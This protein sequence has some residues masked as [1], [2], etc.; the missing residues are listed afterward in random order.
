[1][2]ITTPLL[3]VICHPVVRI[4]IAYM[5]TKFDDFRFSRSSNMT[6]APKLL[7]GHMT[8]PRPYQGRFVV[9]RLW[10]ADSTRSAKSRWYPRWYTFQVIA[11]FLTLI[12]NKQCSGAFEG[13][14][15]IL[16]WFYYKFTAKSVSE[17]TLKIGQCLAE[18]EANI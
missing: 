13:W 15:A 6:G 5:C 7:M 9:R 4:D 2:T 10:I 18:F 12:F 11:V 17:S 8:W 3:C 1:V 16:L 14:L